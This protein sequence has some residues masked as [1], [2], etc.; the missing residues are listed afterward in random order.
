[1]NF[2]KL[3][4]AGAIAAASA[5]SFA[6]PG[7]VIATG[8]FASSWNNPPISF[9]N[10]VAGL[11][12]LGAYNWEVS[13]TTTGLTT[14]TDIMI[15]GASNSPSGPKFFMGTGAGNDTFDLKV[16][17]STSGKEGNWGGSYTLTSAVP[18]PETYALMLAGLG[19]IGYMARRRKA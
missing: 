19:A 3:A 17:A 13:V 16:F 15:N 1:M 11:S 14:L 18:E 4:V 12:G 5:G 6:A 9:S 8:S 7:D 2:K 10:V